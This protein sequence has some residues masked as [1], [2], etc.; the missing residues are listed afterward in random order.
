ME[1]LH[2]SGNLGDLKRDFGTL[3]LY[4]ATKIS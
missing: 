3:G 4:L 2:F 1:I